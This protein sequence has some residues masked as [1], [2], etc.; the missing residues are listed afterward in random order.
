MTL[1][2]TMK[3]QGADKIVRE[4]FHMPVSVPFTKFF[5]GGSINP[6]VNWMFI[7]L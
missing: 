3:A 1:I 6:Q 5:P 2:T 7:K 4:L